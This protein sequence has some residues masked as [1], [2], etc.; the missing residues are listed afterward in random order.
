M[1]TYSLPET[2]R[3]ILIRYSAVRFG[4]TPAVNALAASQ[5]LPLPSDYRPERVTMQAT[6]YYN[7]SPQG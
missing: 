4:I 2:S 3:S 7:E 1:S 6:F 5:L